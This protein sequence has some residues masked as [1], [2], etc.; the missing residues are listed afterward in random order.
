[1]QHRD[2]VPEHASHPRHRLR[3]E[4]DFGNE[5]DRPTTRRDDAAQ[6]L[7]IDERLAGPGDAVDENGDVGRRSGDAVHDAPLVGR[8]V[9][10]RRRLQIRERVARLRDLG[11]A[12]QPLRHQPVHRRA[13][14][15][16]PFEEMFHGRRP[17]QRLQCFVR[18]AA[19]RRARERPLPL[20]QRR[21]SPHQRDHP[22][23]GLGWPGRARHAP[24]RSRQQRAYGE[25]QRRAVVTADPLGQLQ[26]RRR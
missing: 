9:G 13:R 26:Q 6:D 23:S 4:G 5:E 14:E 2:L 18:D 16:E 3:R 25:P 11:V 17:S 22:L 15:L 20:E 8:E 21:Q 10:R 7:E 1:M 12:R 24:Q 19:L